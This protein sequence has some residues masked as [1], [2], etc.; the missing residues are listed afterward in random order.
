MIEVGL[1]QVRK[2]GFE[3]RF[4]SD[5]GGDAGGGDGDGGGLFMIIGICRSR[6]CQSGLSFLH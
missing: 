3:A 6:A 2:T 5:N 1:N 4:E